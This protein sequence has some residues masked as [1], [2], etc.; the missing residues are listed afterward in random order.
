M[1]HANFDTAVVLAR[2]AASI[3]RE[4]D[5]LVRWLKLVHANQKFTKKFH[6][7]SRSESEIQTTEV[8]HIEFLPN[9]SLR[10]AR[11]CVE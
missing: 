3:R 5:P 6:L 11:R 7:K 10:V 1:N 2:L 9:V 4:K 8:G